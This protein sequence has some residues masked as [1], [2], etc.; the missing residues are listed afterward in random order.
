MNILGTALFVVSATLA[1]A[2]FTPVFRTVGVVVALVLFA[3]G[4]ASFILGYF[5]AVQRSRYDNISVAS[6]FLLIGTVSGIKVRRVMNGCLLVQ[7]LCGLITALARTTTDGRSGSTLAF[8]VLVPLFGLGLNGL[9]SSRHGLFSP[10]DNS[11]TIIPN[12]KIGK[13]GV[14]G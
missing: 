3:I 11:K 9:W 6:L 13:D 1:A 8:G 4:V 2:V 7:G 12:P 14:H 10:L 5:T